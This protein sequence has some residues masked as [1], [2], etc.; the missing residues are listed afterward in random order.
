VFQY[1]PGRCP[2]TDS[3]T[4]AR[5]H[6]PVSDPW[7][8]SGSLRDYRKSDAAPNAEVALELAM[9]LPELVYLNPEKI[10]QAWK[11]MRA[12]RAAFVEFFGCDELVLQ[13]AEAEERITP[14]TST[15]KEPRSPGGPPAGGHRTS[16]AWTCPRSSFRMNSPTLTPSASSTTRSTVSAFITS[17]R[18][19]CAA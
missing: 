14:S 16:P 6:P 5:L 19:C 12:D 1:G 15:G 2:S 11:Q 10:G 8:V 7:L 13:P 3:C 9:R 17:T 18:C 4:S